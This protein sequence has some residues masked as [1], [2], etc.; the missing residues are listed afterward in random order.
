MAWDC[1]ALLAF[2]FSVSM[3]Q[4]CT[5]PNTSPDVFFHFFCKAESNLFNF[6]QQ[7]QNS[8][9][10]SYICV[11]QFFGSFMAWDVVCN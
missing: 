4:L 2:D 9:Y 6:Q 11:L 5:R 1:T 8:C 3:Q 10:D 7:Q